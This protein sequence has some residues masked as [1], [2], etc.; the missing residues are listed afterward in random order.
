ML[1]K[2]LLTVV[3]LILFAGAAIGQDAPPTPEVQTPPEVKEDATPPADVAPPVQPA[4]SGLNATEQAEVESI[5]D[6]LLASEK[7][8]QAV[9]S[10][11]E[12]VV[13][14]H[15]DAHLQKVVPALVGK[16]VQA[17][18]PGL[19]GP[20]VRD[21]LKGQIA[22]YREDFATAAT[23]SF[24]KMLAKSG[25]AIPK[26]VSTSTPSAVT[27][28][29]ITSATATPVKMTTTTVPRNQPATEVING[30]LYYLHRDGTYYES[31]EYGQTTSYPVQQQCV[32]NC[33]TR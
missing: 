1:K 24:Q 10:H 3:G 9:E 28:T 17:Q 27:K 20:A 7:F 5:F 33:R 6:N 29:A 15:V 21:Q 12:A 14:K 25:A 8:K 4:E 23:N 13:P 16:E 32:G 11:V 19:V 2:S 31:P 18:L 30:R 26:P 22:E